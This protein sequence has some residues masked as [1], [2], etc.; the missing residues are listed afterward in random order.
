MGLQYGTIIQNAFIVNDM[1]EA[2]ERWN[3]AFGYGPFLLMEH[4]GLKDIVYRGESVEL[5]ISAGFVQ[6]GDIQIEFIQ[7]HNDGPSCYR[8]QFAPG[9]EGFH[10]VAVLCEDYDAEYKRYVDNGFPSATEF[11]S[12]GRQIAYMDTRASTGCMVELYPDVEGIH[13][14]YKTV[15]DIQE[16]WDGKQL[17]WTP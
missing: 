17:V 1:Q 12:G 6:A 16:G 7:Q 13:T 5:D 4:I 11:D 3:K 8:D 14:L 9:E 15:R 10:H 2:M